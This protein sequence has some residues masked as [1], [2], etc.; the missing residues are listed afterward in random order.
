MSERLL[1]DMDGVLADTMGGAFDYIG[2]DLAHEDIAEYWFTGLPAKSL[3]LEAFR[4]KGFYTNLDVITGAV[5]AINRL[6]SEFDVVVCSA[7]IQGAEY[8]EEE[9]REWLEKHWD[10][11]FAEAAI[12]TQ[13]KTLVSGKV[14]VEDN[15]YIGEGTWQPILFDQAWNRDSDLPRMYGWHDL[16]VIRKAMR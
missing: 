13:D 5:R 7:P 1:V 2:N 6:R 3:I 16:D 9:K 15:P 4:S 14:L 11:E 10:R 8:C 12:M